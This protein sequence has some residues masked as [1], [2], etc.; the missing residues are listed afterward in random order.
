M[1][2]ILCVGIDPAPSTSKEA[3]VV[4]VIVTGETLSELKFCTLSHLKL[5]EQLSSWKKEHKNVLISWDAPLTGPQFPDSLDAE[6]QEGD[7][8]ER[9]IEKELKKELPKG[10]KGI[11][12]QGY[13]GCQHWTV[14]RNLFGLPRVGPFDRQLTESDY[15]LLFARPSTW[16]GHWIVETHPAFAIW[17]WLKEK[18][19]SFPSQPVGVNEAYRWCYK[20]SITG[21]HNSAEQKKVREAFLK[22]LCELWTQFE[23]D[24]F[25]DEISGGKEQQFIENAD[26]LDALVVAALAA[27]WVMKPDDIVKLEWAERECAERKGAKREWTERGGAMLLPVV[28][29]SQN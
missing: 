29:D 25:V 7:F 18:D 2:E 21:K 26:L 17:R 10:I 3:G 16:S 27:L 13:A 12:V 6:E 9:P 11:S 28:K 4:Q 15:R 20:T 14:T 22:G 5:R 23:L 19:G 1:E 24:L 8:T